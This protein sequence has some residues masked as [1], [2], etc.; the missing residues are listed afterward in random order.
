MRHDD[1]P[2]DAIASREQASLMVDE[3]PTAPRPLHIRRILVPLGGSGFEQAAIDYAV[4]LAEAL[5]ASI[6]LVH[7]DEQP[8]SMVGIV[9]GAS[10]EG[11]LAAARVAAT[12]WLDTLAQALVDRGVAQPE[13][14][15]VEAVAVT[16]ALVEL[17]RREHF[18]LVVMATHARMGLS[19]LVHGSVAEQM[20]RR[21]P[22]PVLTVHIP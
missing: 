17:A 4:L 2:P 1:P 18:D 5:S 19:R 14:V 3:P 16:P 8:G 13:T 11:D 15:I 7:V 20:L 9:P 6:T 22:C 10:V 12:H 21:A